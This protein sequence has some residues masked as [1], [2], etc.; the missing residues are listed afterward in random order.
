MTFLRYFPGMFAPMSESIMKRACE[1][2]LAEIN[3][4]NIRDYAKDPHLADDIL[5]G[6]GAGMVLKTGA[7]DECPSERK[8][9]KRVIP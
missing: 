2:G 6:G 8:V 5:Y 9:I 4:H 1:K 3:I 7:C